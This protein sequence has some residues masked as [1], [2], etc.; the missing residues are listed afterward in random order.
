[1][2]R[3]R[4]VSGHMVAQLLTAYIGSH[5]AMQ[6]LRSQACQSVTPCTQHSA[7]STPHNSLLYF[8]RLC[9]RLGLPRHRVLCEALWR[10]RHI[11]LALPLGRRRQQR[12]PPALAAAC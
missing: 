1:M 9:C 8:C 12:P 6:R 2:Q 11:L 3:R 7:A 5:R 10:E 4:V